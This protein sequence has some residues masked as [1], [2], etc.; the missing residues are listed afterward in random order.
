MKF[1]WDPA[2]ASANEK[3][4]S[5]TFEEAVSVF[6]DPMFLIFADPDHSIN[7]ARFLALGVSDSGALLMVSYTERPNA[8]RLISARKA[9]RRE[10][11]KYEEEDI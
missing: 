5:V 9:S 3:K 4:H 10:R 1:E 11:K 8:T 7:E 6:Q 2:K